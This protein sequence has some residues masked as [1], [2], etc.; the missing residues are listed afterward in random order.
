MKRVFFLVYSLNCG[1]TCSLIRSIDF[2][3]LGPIGDPTTN[4]VIPALSNRVILLLHMSG[5]PAI[6]NA[7]I[8][9]G[10]TEPKALPK[11][12][13][14]RAP[15]ILLAASKFSPCLSNITS[16]LPATIN[17]TTGEAA[18]VAFSS[19]LCTENEV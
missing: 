18:L 16:G 11:S 13:F 9:S 15:R 3:T 17:A 14:F 19:F 4:W 8:I 1:I 12:P 10:D 7:S 6:E 2:L 5:V